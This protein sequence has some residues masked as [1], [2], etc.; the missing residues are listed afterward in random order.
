MDDQS[1]S[2]CATAVLNVVVVR[3]GHYGVML[4]QQVAR[5]EREGRSRPEGQKQALF[6]CA[7]AMEREGQLPIDTLQ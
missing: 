7:V 6:L 1:T 5:S 4:Q 2:H 3:V